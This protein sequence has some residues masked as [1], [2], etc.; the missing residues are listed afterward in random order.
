MSKSKVLLTDKSNPW[1]HGFRDP[2]AKL[3]AF[4]QS[5]DLI[6]LAYDGENRLVVGDFSSN[7][8]F[9]YKGINIEWAID[10]ND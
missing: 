9:G 7:K 10:V 2:V 3:S 6:P 5:I 4:S 1:L 8:V